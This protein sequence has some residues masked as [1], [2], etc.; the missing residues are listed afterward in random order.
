MLFK[1]KW[2]V[3]KFQFT[4]IAI[5]WNCIF[6]KLDCEVIRAIHTYAVP[7]ILYDTLQAAVN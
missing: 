4:D 6:L 5:K 3:Y 7:Y 2:M 1:Y